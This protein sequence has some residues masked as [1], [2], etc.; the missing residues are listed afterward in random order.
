[1]A[2]GNIVHLAAGCHVS[3]LDHHKLKVDNKSLYS[4]W[5][6]RQVLHDIAEAVLSTRPFN[7]V[8]KV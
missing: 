5:H 8:V 2:D 6:E 3:V 1:M 7:G 4:I